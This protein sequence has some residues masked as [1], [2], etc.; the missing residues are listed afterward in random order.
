MKVASFGWEADQLKDKPVTVSIPILSPITI[1][2]YQFDIGMMAWGDPN[3]FKGQLPGWSEVLFS[4]YFSGLAGDNGFGPATFTTADTNQNLHGNNV[5]HMNI[6]RAILK[7]YVST[8][9]IGNAVNKDITMSGLDIYVRIGS[10]FSMTAALAGFGPMDFEVQG[11]LFYDD[12][13]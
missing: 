12:A 8:P 11:V 4:A 3:V 7:T 13:Q 10:T 1:R 2:G 9:A 5:D 6:C